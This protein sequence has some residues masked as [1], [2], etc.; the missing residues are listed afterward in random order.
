MITIHQKAMVTAAYNL[1]VH[2]GRNKKPDGKVEKVVQVESIP[3]HSAPVG[4]PG[5]SQA[6][7]QKG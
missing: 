6:V 3:G 5:A 2:D 4:N 7:R 1:G